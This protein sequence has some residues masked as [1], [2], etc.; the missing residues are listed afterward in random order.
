[1]AVRTSTEQTFRSWDGTDLF[2]RAW[3]A[4]P[5]SGK[6]LLLFHRG[7][8][9]SGRFQE[10]VDRL[11]LGDV[12]V[13][14]WDARGH[15]RSPGDRGYAPDLGW[16]VKDLDAFVRHLSGREKIPPENVV[17][18]G[19]SVGAVILAAWVHDYAPPLRGLVLA[20]PAFRVRLYVPLAVPALRAL[21]AI[22]P[23]AH[24]ASYVKSRM[25]THDPEAAA[26][27][28]RDPLITRNIPVNILLDLHDAGTRLLSDAGAITTPTLLI[29][30]G[31]DWV[32]DLD[33]QRR[34]FAGLSSLR[35]EMHVYDGFFHAVYHEQD[36]GRPLARTR[37]FVRSLFDSPSA[38]V[39]TANP[40]ADGF[41]RREHERLARPLPLASP[42]RWA[43]A[44]CAAAMRTA[45]RLSDG[46]ALGWRTG[47]DSGRTLDYVYENRPRGRG[48]VGRGM[49]RVYLNS[50]GWKGI[51]LRKAHVEAALGS[52]IGVLRSEG[53][54]VRILDIAAGPGRYV[55]ETMRKFAGPDMTALLRDQTPQNL[56]AGRA[57]ARE[58]GVDG[59]AFAEG[60]A[61]DREDLAG[62]RPRPTLAIVSGLYEL[63]PDNDRVEGS[64]RGLAEAVEAGG[65][66]VYTNQPWHPQIEFIARVL[67]NRDGRPWIMRRRTQAEMDRLVREAGFVKE[68]MEVD[69]WGIFTVSLA[70]RR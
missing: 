41:T 21:R 22:R 12:S 44:A 4:D 23:R 59:A 17:A 33:A 7:H 43:Y 13:F 54:P 14:A 20:T 19:H 6:A 38:A 1:M 65:F 67:I 61:F 39:P 57:L 64:L 8:E 47:F 51:R 30:A 34:F 29:G 49:D 32:V 5:P 53:K 60:D 37:E 36:R 25:L 70:R 35:K 27:Y 69:P 56:E 55:L 42:R 24:V 46:I 48:V 2:Y 68:R 52:A 62:L 40:D 15:G 45:G 31:T 28:D 58:L 11:D 9:H 50:P 63:F 10:F 26:A 3:R 66:L 18:L 16:F